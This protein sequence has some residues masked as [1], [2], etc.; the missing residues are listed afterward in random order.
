MLA[1]VDLGHVAAEER[2]DRDQ[3][4]TERE[5]LQPAIDR[6]G[7]ELLSADQCVRQVDADCDG[8]DQAEEVGRA[9]VRDEKG[10]RGH[11][12]SMASMIR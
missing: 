8:D 4:R 3:Y 6:H 9:H 2:R 7:L 1:A 12:R 10:Q 11:T 5:D